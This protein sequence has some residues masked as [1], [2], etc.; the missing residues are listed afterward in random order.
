MEE[1]GGSEGGDSRCGVDK[2]AGSRGASEEHVQKRR[3]GKGELEAAGGTEEG[4]LMYCT[5]AGGRGADANE[6]RN[7]FLVRWELWPM[8]GGASECVGK[9]VVCV[10]LSNQIR[11]LL[12]TVEGR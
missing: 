12:V 8:G 7:S 9:M 1:P 3:E 10:R 2:E 6:N 4:R 11:G 5:S